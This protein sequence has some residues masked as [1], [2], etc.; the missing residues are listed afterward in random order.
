MDETTDD[1]ESEPTMNTDGMGDDDK[2]INGASEALH[3]DAADSEGG[4]E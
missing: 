1:L 4:E 2:L 3:D